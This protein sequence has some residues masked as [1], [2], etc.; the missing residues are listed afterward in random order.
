LQKAHSRSQ[1]PIPIPA[2]CNAVRPSL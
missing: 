1:Q 2:A